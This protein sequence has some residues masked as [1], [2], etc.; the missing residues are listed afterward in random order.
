MCQRETAVRRPEDT[1]GIQDAHSAASVEPE[2]GAA[3]RLVSGHCHGYHHRAHLPTQGQPV[4]H[5]SRSR[6]HDSQ[7]R[8]RY[9]VSVSFQH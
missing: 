1:A 5:G 8:Q 7:Q 3:A 2:A 4:S 6:G 9:L